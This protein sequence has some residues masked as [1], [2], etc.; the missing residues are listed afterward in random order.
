MTQPQPGAMGSVPRVNLMPPEIA[1]GARLRQI[2]MLM[3]VGV[4]LAVVVVALLYMHEHSKVSGAQSQL[5][6]AQ[7]AQA[8]L[9]SKL[10]TLSSVSET[11]AAVQAKQG[12]LTSALGGEVRW[13]YVLSDLSLR[14]PHNVVLTTMSASETTLSAAPTPASDPAA[15]PIGTMTFSGSALR[16]DDVAAWLD[17]LA[18]EKGFAT[19][20]FSSSTETTSG[21][22]TFS[23]SVNVTSSAESGRYAAAPAAE[24]TTP[25]SVG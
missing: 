12:L 18:K 1:A 24:P 9:N 5:T 10:A 20:T 3:G 22:V 2:Q 7:D 4:L 15:T 6:A 8:G 23:T 11:F 21:T 25:E 14:I 16:H 19:P 13:S 17:S